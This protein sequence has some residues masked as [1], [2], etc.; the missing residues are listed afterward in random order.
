M[1]YLEIG[2]V[3]FLSYAPT[4]EGGVFSSD[5]TESEAEAVANM[6]REQFENQ[7]KNHSLS[8]DLAVV[9]VEFDTGC[10]YTFLTIA[11]TTAVGSATIVHFVTKYK[12]IREALIL[13]LRDG[14][15][16]I[17]IATDKN[18]TFRTW[19]YSD[20]V[21]RTGNMSEWNSDLEQGKITEAVPDK[22]PRRRNA[23]KKNE[24]TATDA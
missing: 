21:F 11:L 17:K 22:K 3:V 18:K 16:L 1:R 20:K 19:L 9:R 4:F 10:V 5:S 12:K 6:V 15:S 8:E 14:D 7:L 2:E 24:S 23:K 13:M